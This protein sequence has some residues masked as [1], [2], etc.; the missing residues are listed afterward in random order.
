MPDASQASIAGKTAHPCK[1]GCGLTAVKRRHGTL[2]RDHRGSHTHTHMSIYTYIIYIYI[3]YIYTHIYIN[4]IQHTYN[5]IASPWRRMDA[6]LMP[7]LC[8]AA[9]EEIPIPAP[10][11]SPACSSMCLFAA[12]NARFA[13]NRRR[14]LIAKWIRLLKLV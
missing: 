3:L 14:W 8:Y 6:N 11:M 9:G 7:T 2:V 13:S 1:V 12:R 4:I 10:R 5:S